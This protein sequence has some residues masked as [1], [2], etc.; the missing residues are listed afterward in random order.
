MTPR[1]RIMA[2]LHGDMPDRIPFTCYSGL[3]PRGET[4]RWLREEGAAAGG[5]KGRESAGPVI[6]A[7][8]AV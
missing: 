7:A 3:L 8:A 4:E 2:A 1:E 6:G 5:L